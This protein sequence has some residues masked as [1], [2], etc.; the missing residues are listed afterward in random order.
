[1]SPRSQVGH[2][3]SQPYVAVL[4]QLPFL[5]VQAVTCTFKRFESEAP[6]LVELEP[7]FLDD[8]AT[9]TIASY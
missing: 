9:H 1:M 5:T 7:H 2:F 3:V 4:F 8:I 6:L